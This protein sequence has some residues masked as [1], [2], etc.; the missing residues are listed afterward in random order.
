MRKIIFVIVTLL[1][2]SACSVER[3]QPIAEPVIVPTY[4]SAAPVD[5]PEAPDIDLSAVS[6]EV[7]LDTLGDEYPWLS[8]AEMLDFAGLACT[9]LSTGD[10]PLTAASDITGMRS[11]LDGMT[12]AAVVGAAFGSFYCEHWS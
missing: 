6:R 5:A 9:E 4:E 7:Y 12:A 2:F 10:D 8:E 11:R 1:T 3:E